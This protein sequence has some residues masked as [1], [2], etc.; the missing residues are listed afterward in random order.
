VLTNP[1]PR[2]EEIG[3]YYGNGYYAY[4]SPDTASRKDR[5]KDIVL[6]ELGGYPYRT[7]VPRILARPVAALLRPHIMVVPPY[8]PGGALLDAGCGA[9]SFL[10]WAI[11]AGWSATGLEIDG[12]AVQEARRAGLPVVHG[13]M[14]HCPLPDAA[15]DTVVLN[16]TLEHCH[17]PNR[18]LAN[19]ARVLKPG[20]LLIAGVPN[21]ACYDN[22]VFQ[23]AWSNCEAPRHLYHFTPDT[24]PKLL[25]KHGFRLER[26]RFKTW[27]IPYSERI[28]FRFLRR[29]LAGEPWPRRARAMAIA[30]VRIQALKKLAQILRLWPDRE[31][32]QMM[33]AYARRRE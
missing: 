5:V 6:A 2:P 1:R 4:L 29:N 15:Y 3:R 16:H 11:R 14:E 9:G 23:D 27:F 32:A 24:L 10:R 31:L 8:V 30:R 13:S 12:R 33:T 7:G 18:A 21:F 17:D 28:S 19:C 25:E 26:L 20:G 22:L